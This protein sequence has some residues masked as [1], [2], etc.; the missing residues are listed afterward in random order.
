MLKFVIGTFVLMLL[1]VT[2]ASFPAEALL[3]LEPGNQEVAVAAVPDWLEPHGLHVV[4]LVGAV[5]E[6]QLRD[7]IVTAS[8]SS[9]I[10]QYLEGSREGNRV[11]IKVRLWPRYLKSPGDYTLIGCLNNRVYSDYWATTVPEAKMRVYSGS[12]NITQ[13]IAGGS[14][15]PAGWVHPAGG[16]IDKDRYAAP[17]IGPMQSADEVLIPANRGCLLFIEGRHSDLTAVFTYN[18]EKKISVQ[19]MGQE[20][21]SYGGYRGIGFA[22]VFAPLQKQLQKYGNRHDKFALNIPAGAD[23]V[24][25]KFPPS[26]V[27]QDAIDDIETNVQQPSSGTYRLARDAQALSVDHNVSMGLPLNSMWRDSDQAGGKYLSLLPKVNTISALEYFVPSGIDYD[28]CMTRGDCPESL[29]QEIISK[30]MN[31]TVYYYKVDR[32]AEGLTRI[33]LR[34]VGPQWS[35]QD[36]FA[37]GEHGV[38]VERA[39]DLSKEEISPA[40]SHQIFLPVVGT[41]TPPPELPADDANGCPCGWFTSEG[42]MVDYVAGP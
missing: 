34:Q 32:I 12:R 25:V 33:P 37:A 5:P 9:G 36:A 40:A 17:P 6:E 15:T 35:P 2:G 21:F 38:Q 28:Q 1:L 22:G 18:F 10:A 31:M 3:A 11:T 16:A 19:A 24:F 39:S 42:R 26:T 27:G 8:P 30:R 23:Y 13:R 7:A 29:M 4:D 14:I 41:G 20:T